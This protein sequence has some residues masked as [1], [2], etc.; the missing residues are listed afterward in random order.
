MGS[1]MCTAFAGLLFACMALS[2]QLGTAVIVA[3]ALFLLAVVLWVLF[4]CRLA[5][6]LGDPKFRGATRAFVAGCG[7]SFLVVVVMMA[8]VTTAD[9]ARDP[10]EAIIWQLR[11]GA[12]AMSCLAL[13]TTSF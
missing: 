6:G 4:F 13:V 10:S 9:L 3:S 12:P 5:V 7:L 11:A 8:R 2:G 1:A